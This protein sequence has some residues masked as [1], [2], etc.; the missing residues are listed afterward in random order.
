MVNISNFTLIQA[1]PVAQLRCWAEECPSGG[2]ATWIFGLSSPQTYFGKMPV[3]HLAD[4]LDWERNRVLSRWANFFWFLKWT[5]SKSIN[6][7]LS[8]NP[9]LGDRHQSSPWNSQG[10][11]LLLFVLLFFSGPGPPQLHV[12]WNRSALHV[13]SWDS[14]YVARP[15][16]RGQLHFFFIVNDDCLYEWGLGLR[17]FANR[18][19]LRFCAFRMRGRRRTSQWVQ[20]LSPGP[21]KEV[22]SWRGSPPLKNFRSWVVLWALLGE[23][24]LL[25]QP[26][27]FIFCLFLF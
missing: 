15:L 26:S 5:Q 14:V 24:I 22:K 11:H 3:S 1:L 17:L 19:K 18:T 6:R 27:Y 7:P 12:G 16:R 23:Y 2:N 21:W 13:C 25:F 8:V 20:T 10:Q 4:Q 9:P